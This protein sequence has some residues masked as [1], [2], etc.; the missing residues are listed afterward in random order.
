MV[1]RAEPMQHGA[2]N[3][4]S[5]IEAIRKEIFTGWGGPLWQMVKMIG[6]VEATEDKKTNYPRR[7]D[8]KNREEQ[9]PSLGY[10]LKN[11]L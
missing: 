9:E 5:Y 11:T 10:T 3:E 2:R 7:K 8:E 6:T 4:S 1:E